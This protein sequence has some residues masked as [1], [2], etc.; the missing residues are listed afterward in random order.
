[1]CSKICLFDCHMCRSGTEEE[2]SEL[3]RYLEDIASYLCDMSAIQATQAAQ[4]AANRKKLKEDK[5]KGE[6]MRRAAMESIA[7]KLF[8]THCSY[9]CMDLPLPPLHTH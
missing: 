8:M 7:S 5:K 1:M 4:R 9:L 2:Y 3:Q 6:E